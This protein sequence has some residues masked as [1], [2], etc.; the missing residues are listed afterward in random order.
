M[1]YFPLYMSDSLSNW[2]L[3]KTTEIPLRIF[4]KHLEKYFTYYK[5][6][7]CIIDTK[8]KICYGLMKTVNIVEKGRKKKV[9]ILI[10]VINSMKIINTW[11]LLK[12]RSNKM[13]TC[14]YIQMSKSITHAHSNNQWR[15]ASWL[16][17]A[18]G[19]VFSRYCIITA[20][21]AFISRTANVRIYIHSYSEL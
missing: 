1:P 6:Y 15:R 17:L 12:R 3:N 7:V 14:T 18:N 11:P 5:K 13:G 16:W 10:A 21:F 20:T 2:L 9:Q 4:S 8:W 19:L